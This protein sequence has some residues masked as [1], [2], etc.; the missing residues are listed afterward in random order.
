M[1]F[2]ADKAIQYDDI[3]ETIDYDYITKRII[4]EVEDS[5]YF[6]LEKLADNIL[7]IIT[8]DVKIIKASVE[9]DKLCAITLADSVSIISNFSRHGKNE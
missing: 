1:E 5:Q 2:Y 6:L 7:N 4:K 9:I 3:N 8:E